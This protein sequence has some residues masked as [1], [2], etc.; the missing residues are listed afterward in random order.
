MAMVGRVNG[1]GRS[2][3]GLRDD[4]GDVF[5]A[6]GAFIIAG[7]V[8]G[9]MAGIIAAGLLGGGN[10]LAMG[11]SGA[12]VGMIMGSF[13]GMSLGV[14]RVG[15]P[16]PALRPEREPVPQPAPSPQLWDPWLDSGRD[17]EWVASEGESEPVVIEE[18]QVIIERA[19]GLTA[20]RCAGPAPRHL[21]R[22][23][24]GH[25]AGG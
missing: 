1:R 18:P 6:L 4:R 13:V 3:E 8:L 10:S 24:R 2:G 21:A 15:H 25:R 14:W 12:V 16:T 9:G 7:V 20:E 23:R 5:P 22:D 19:E 11:T 17:A